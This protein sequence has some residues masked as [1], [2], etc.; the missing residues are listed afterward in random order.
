MTV[1]LLI[2]ADR[3][4]HRLIERS[5]SGVDLLSGMPVI[6]FISGSAG[7]IE[8]CRPQPVIRHKTAG[9]NCLK[10]YS[11][12]LEAVF[13]RT[14]D[15]RCRKYAANSVNSEHAPYFVQRTRR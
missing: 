10:L 11:G 9:H 3:W 4:L 8:T 5:F 2:Y 15:N 7:K 14:S 12:S 13:H 1:A 6:G